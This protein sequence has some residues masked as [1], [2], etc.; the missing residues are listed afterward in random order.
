MVN[1]LPAPKPLHGRKLI[2]IE[3]P[4][5]VA[6]RT[7]VKLLFLPGA[8]GSGAFWHPVACRLDWQSTLFSWPG[9]GNEPSDPEVACVSDLI[10]LVAKEVDRP[11]AIIAQSMGG[12]I[13]IKLALQFPELVKCLVLVATSGGVP[14]QDLGGIDW[15]PSYEARF[16]RAEKWIAKPVEDLSPQLGKL[17]VPVLLIWG[18]ADPISP[19][20]VGER[21]LSLLPN[22]SLQVIEGADHDLAETHADAVAVLIRE[23]VKAAMKP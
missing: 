12:Y 4:K 14:I 10:S 5:E 2:A 16:P 8:S 7:M 20:A 17:Q 6:A 11:L 23:H 21:L 19:V 15:R 18:D 9:L 1:R 3:A 22:S 13:A